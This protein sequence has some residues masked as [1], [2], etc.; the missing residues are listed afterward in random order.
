MVSP[1]P[2]NTV[3]T[4]TVE[5]EWDEYISAITY[6]DVCIYCTDEVEPHQPQT[7]GSHVSCYDKHMAWVDY[8]WS[9]IAA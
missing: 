7:D 2:A 5:R 9:P 6:A 1:N 8:H 4:N 3:E